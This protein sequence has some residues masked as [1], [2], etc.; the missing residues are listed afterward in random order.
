MPVD[1]QGHSRLMCRDKEMPQRGGATGN[2]DEILEQIE[3]KYIKMALDETYGI[4][5]Q[6]AKVLGITHRTMRFRMQKFGINGF[7]HK[8]SRPSCLDHF[9]QSLT[10]DVSQLAV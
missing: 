9:C 8:N 5:T 10:G 4:V 6:A 1:A 2:L 7:D 3:I